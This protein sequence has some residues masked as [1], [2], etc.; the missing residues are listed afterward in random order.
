MIKEIFMDI[1]LSLWLILWA[2]RGYLEAVSS[3]ALWE[4]MNLPAL[5]H[6]EARSQD[7]SASIDLVSKPSQ[8]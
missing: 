5:T 1:Q 3:R 8:M 6:L 7:K 4:H 2:Y